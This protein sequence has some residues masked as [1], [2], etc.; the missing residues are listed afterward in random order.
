MLRYVVRENGQVIA[1]DENGQ[2]I[3]MIDP[4]TGEAQ[5]LE[6]AGNL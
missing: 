2:H 1:R 3:A 6:L 5:S 4:T